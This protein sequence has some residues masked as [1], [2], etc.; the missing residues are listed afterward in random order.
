MLQIPLSLSGWIANW[1]CS[2]LKRIL[3]KLP[4]KKLAKGMTFLGV[5]LGASSSYAGASYDE[6]KTANT[7]TAYTN[8][9]L[10]ASYRDNISRTEV[11]EAFCRLLELDETA[12]QALASDLVG[13]P[14]SGNFVIR[15]VALEECA[16]DGFAHFYVI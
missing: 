13:S 8:F 12:A 3:R 14:L 6:A 9:I 11:E 1:G 16:T 10:G 7:V 4:K 15:N 2:V 5:F